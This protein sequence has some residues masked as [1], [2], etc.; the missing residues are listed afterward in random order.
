MRTRTQ[1]L[2]R[3]AL[4]SLSLGAAALLAPGDACAEADAFGLGNGHSGAY[5]AAAANEVI[6]AYAPLT[7]AAA[8]GA[9]QISIGGKVGAASGFVVGDLVMLW[10]ATGLA[11][12]DA[13]S[14]SQTAVD[15]ERKPPAMPITVG[16]FELARISAATATAL[17][18]TK[19]LTQA[20]VK[21]VT[22]VLTVPEYTTMAVAAGTGPAA[23][24][25][26]TAG[27]GFAGGI[28][29]FLATGVATINGHVNAD[30]RGFR[31]G[32]LDA[33]T[34][35]KLM[36]AASDGIESDGYAAKGEG[37]V[38]SEFGGV[39]HGGK[40]NRAN[41]AGGGNCAENGGGG[42][43]NAG[44]GGSGGNSIVVG[45]TGG[46]LGGARLDY[47]LLTRL[48]MG[49]GG[50]A[51]EQKNGVGSGGGAGGGVVF[52][53]VQSLAG[54][55]Q[56]TADGAT[57]TNAGIAAN[58]ESD[59]AGGGGAGGSIL[60]RAVGNVTCAAAQTK[61]GDGGKTGVVNIGTFGPGGGGSGGRVLVQAKDSA[62]CPITVTPGA[63]GVAGGGGANGA[64]PGAPGA[65]TPAP[66]GNYCFSNDANDVQCAP[67]SPV[68]DPATGF[69]NKCT[70]PFAGGS[71]HAC[72]LPLAPVC[73][74]A[75]TCGPCD[76]DF[77][78]GSTSACQLTG[79][80]YCN[81]TEAA[82]AGSC[83]T[84]ARDADCAGAGHAGTLCNV[85]SGTC[86]K[87]CVNDSDCKA[88]LEW[89]AG[90]PG[91]CIPKTPNGQHVPQQSPIDGNCTM[92]NGVRVCL[93][94][95]CETSDN[96]CGLKN[97]SPCAGMSA[98]CRSNICFAGDSLCG[99]PTGEPC[100]V[101]GECRSDMCVGGVCSGCTDDSNCGSG[102]VCDKDRSMCVAGCREVA[103]KSNCI[104]PLQCSKH[105]GT[106]GTCIEL[107]DGGVDGGTDGGAVIDDSGSIEGGGCACR[108]S[109]PISGSPL[110]LAAAVIGALVVGARRRRDR[111]DRAKQ[112]QTTATDTTATDTTTSNIQ[113]R[114]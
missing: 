95:V 71:A 52:A 86:G 35:V 30:A 31:G 93:S 16:R 98:E 61:G 6:N 12:D 77:G 60:I 22:Q 21:D 80:P 37:V 70:G 13:P 56:I 103:G 96:L 55:G 79:A 32:K 78:T 34:D 4:V 47:S 82:S 100:A 5:V 84:C 105:D 40:G 3:L 90:T 28:V 69:C 26:Q 99:K 114:G 17:T 38:A 104:A 36:C 9:T 57:A 72:A 18:F 48:A 23:L 53:R 27:T 19:P 8:I 58:L 45:G 43:G 108:T 20:F 29:A 46:G 88:G 102:K 97:G 92:Q 42:G 50:G 1:R 67:A 25:W 111:N 112:A 51:G 89:C 73:A 91:V 87:A 65:G 59:G 63:A 49:G 66:G 10:Q 85:A 74:P 39:T 101:V 76:G 44:I 11:G 109:M 75:G 106:I 24:A 2:F 7:A 14:G 68:C 83:G 15:L 81:I 54:S 110:A 94:T 107:G 33:N 64:S 113:E 62:G 41:G